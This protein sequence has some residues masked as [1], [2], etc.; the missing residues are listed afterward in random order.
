MMGMLFYL[1]VGYGV[2]FGLQNKF[3]FLYSEEY[4][5]TG[6]PHRVLD[7]LLHCT[8]CTGF[9]MGWVVWLLS[10]AVSSEPPANGWQAIPSVLLWSFASAA[11]SYVVDAIVRWL[12]ANTEV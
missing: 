1:L 7:R 6:E 9:H 2:C 8:Y 5:K 11:F 4:R 10:W 12:E 3:P